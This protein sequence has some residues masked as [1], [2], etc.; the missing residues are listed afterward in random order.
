MELVQVEVQAIGCL[1][2][3]PLSDKSLRQPNIGLR[4]RGLG[5][6]VPP[7]VP[8]FSGTFRISDASQLGTV[9]EVVLTTYHKGCRRSQDYL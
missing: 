8:C 6:R 3:K 5:V 4:N 1:L 9:R 2:H 7:G